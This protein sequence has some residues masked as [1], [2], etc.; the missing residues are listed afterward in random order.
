M[1]WAAKYTATIATGQGSARRQRRG[2]GIGRGSGG[3]RS[4]CF[5]PLVPM[6]APEAGEVPPAFVVRSSRRKTQPRRLSHSY[7]VDVASWPRRWT[8]EL[9]GR[10]RVF[11]APCYRLYR[12]DTG[13]PAETDEPFETTLTL[14]YQP[15]ETFEDGI[16]WLAMS[17][18]DGCLD[19]G[20]LPI[21]PRGEPYVRLDISGGELINR[22]PYGPDRWG[23]VSGGAGIVRVTGVYNQQDSLR[24]D[25][26]AVTYTTDGGM[27][28][29]PPAVSPTVTVAIGAGGMAVLDHVLPAVGGGTTVKVRLQVRRDDGAGGYRYSEDSEVQSM[30]SDE[31]GGVAGSDDAVG[32]AVWPGRMPQE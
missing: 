18:F 10:Y 5:A 15:D 27:P 1:A 17:Y 23:L 28:G 25:A 6:A 12:S 16:W 31:I 30:V 24:G 8:F 22:P 21:G 11:N 4:R 3:R 20:F 9:R 2:P 19:S 29:T 32:A 14:P 7:A 13:P 26:W